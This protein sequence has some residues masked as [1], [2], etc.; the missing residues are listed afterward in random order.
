[1]PANHT[2]PAVGYWLDSGKSSLVFSGDTGPCPEFWQAVNEIDNLRYLIVETAF[3]NRERRLAMVSK[4]LCPST[5]AEQL[6]K[7][8]QPAEIYITHLKPGHIELTMQEIEEG[9]GQ[10]RPHMLENDQI[11]EI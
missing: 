5:L 11:F 10:F 4:H 2:V 6:T 8:R 1:L 7:L 3:P 9:L